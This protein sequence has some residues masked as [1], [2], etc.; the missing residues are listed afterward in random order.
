MDGWLRIP[1]GQVDDA[2]LMGLTI[3]GEDGQEWRMYVEDGKDYLLP[4][5]VFRELHGGAAAL[6]DG[7]TLGARELGEL[8][9]VTLR[10]HQI[11]AVEVTTNR[12]LDEFGTMLVAAPGRGKT[13]MGITIACRLRRPTL[14]LVHKRFL[15]DQWEERIGEFAPGATVGR[16][17]QGR[18]DSGEEYDF[19]LASVS[20][21]VSRTEKGDPKYLAALQTFGTAIFDECH[22]YAADTWQR[23]ITAVPARY[24]LGLT[25][26]VERLDGMEIVLFRHV[27]PVGYEVEGNETTPAIYRFPVISDIDPTSRRYHAWSDGPGVHDGLNTA[28]LLS[29]LAVHRGRNRMLLDY[30]EKA[31]KAGRKVILLSDRLEQLEQLAEAATVRTGMYVGGASREALAEAASA[32]LI[33][34]TYAMAK[35]GLDIPSMD[36]LIFGTPKASVVQ[37]VG[38]ICRSYTGKKAPT[39]VD[40][41][42]TIPAFAALAASRLRKYERNGYEVHIMTKIHRV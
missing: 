20:S 32:D 18:A 11:P 1:K 23:S 3:H 2:M 17:A 37:A 22:R 10:P 28:R 12:L 25:A 41:M 5:S 40:P 31:V 4:R 27:G 36:T 39:V 7:S 14:V 29:D 9:D 30:A 33:L 21:V 42:D 38:R 16:M 35:E 34:S 15:M 19:V 26:T 8:G 13:V 24:R 6:V